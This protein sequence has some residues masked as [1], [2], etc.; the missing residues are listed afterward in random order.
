[1]WSQTW[2][3]KMWV[4]GFGHARWTPTMLW[5]MSTSTGKR[6]FFFF[7]L[8]VEQICLS[9]EEVLKM[10]FLVLS[11]YFKAAHLQTNTNTD[12]KCRWKVDFS[13]EI[14]AQVIN[15]LIN[16]KLMFP[17]KKSPSSVS[18][19][20]GFSALLC[21]IFGFWTVVQIFYKNQAVNQ[22]DNRD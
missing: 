6:S 22:E 21:F 13:F 20:W 7:F 3:A 4:N 12:R 10:F 9:L 14:R 18:P 11:S 8:C 17:P 15:Y 2:G 19:L 1:M 16:Q 5:Q